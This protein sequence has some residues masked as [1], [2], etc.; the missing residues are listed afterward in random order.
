MPEPKPDLEMHKSHLIRGNI[1]G[2]I[3]TVQA[4][5][6]RSLEGKVGTD[7]FDTVVGGLGDE[8]VAAV[9]QSIVEGQIDDSNKVVASLRI[10][11]S[12]R[13]TNKDFVDIISTQRTHVPRLGLVG[14]GTGK[15]GRPKDADK[16]IRMVAIRQ[17]CGV[18]LKDKRLNRNLLSRVIVKR[19]I[20]SVCNTGEERTLLV[21]R[22]PS[23][24]A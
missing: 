5:D 14:K 11:I 7:S 13:D 20:E 21:R 15:V 9:T 16:A 1:P 12:G 3:G 24:G 18:S 19:H 4:D 10:A 17:R 22:D 8:R 6:V 2:N 23:G